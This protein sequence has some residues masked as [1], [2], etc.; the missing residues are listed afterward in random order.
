MLIGGFE[1]MS[2]CGSSNPCLWRKKHWG[3]REGGGN[4]LS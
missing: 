1:Q 3:E 2:A 4:N